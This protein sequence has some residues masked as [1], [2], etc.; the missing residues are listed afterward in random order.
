LELKIVFLESLFD[1]SID[2]L[3]DLY[4]GGTE[5]EPSDLDADYRGSVP[6]VVSESVLGKLS[7]PTAVLSR[8][9]LLPWRGKRFSRE[10][11]RGSNQVLFQNLSVAPFEFLSAESL[12]DGDP[13]LLL[14]YGISQNP[15]ILNYLRDEV[16]RID[17]GILLGQM[18]FKPTSSLALYFALERRF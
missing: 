3:H 5:P 16:R 8:W 6:G 17:D 15:F 4:R 9:G 13:C 11:G 2:E 1:K 18:Y 7:W 14:N 10:E 12:F